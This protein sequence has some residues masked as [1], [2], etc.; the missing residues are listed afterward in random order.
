MR[1]IISAEKRLWGALSMV[2]VVLLLFGA[3]ATPSTPGEEKKVVEF[4]DITPLTGAVS[5]SEQATVKGRTD[6]VKYFNEIEGIP[7]VNVKH[8]W[9]DIGLSV[10]MGMS[11]YRRFV[12]RGVPVLTSSYTTVLEPLKPQ[13]AVDEIPVAIGLQDEPLFYPPGWVYGAAPT[14]A[15]TFTALADYIMENWKQE[16]PPR[17]AF[18]IVDSV[19]GWAPVGEGTKYAESIG[20]EMLPVEMVPYMV[21]DAT[22]QLLRLDERGADFVYVMGLAPTAG[23]MLRDAERLGLLDKINFCGAESTAGEMLINMAGDAAEGYMFPK[24]LPWIDETDIT[25]IKLMVDNQ[26][27]WYGKVHKENPYVIG[28][29]DTARICEGI[30]RAVDTVGYENINGPAVKAA[31]DGMKDYD[32]YGIVNITYTPEDHRGS[33]MVAVYQ[34]KDGKIVRV[35]DWRHAPMLVPDK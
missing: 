9:I 2:L 24:V 30:R 5:S 11:A 7:G 23:P 8:S 21:I 12:E 28:W 13:L 32:T 34:V 17:L 29:V 27:K 22:P 3:C 35:S 26:M 18:V 4:G 31:F 6:Y 10:S 20:I 19:Y 1:G 14:Y 33:D 25:G 16:R 15:E